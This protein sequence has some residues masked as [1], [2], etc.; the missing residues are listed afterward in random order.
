MVIFFFLVYLAKTKAADLIGRNLDNVF[1]Y[2]IDNNTMR[3]FG[4]NGGRY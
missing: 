2:L 3:M 1:F 4:G